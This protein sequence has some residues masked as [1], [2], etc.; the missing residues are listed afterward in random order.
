[1]CCIFEISW[2]LLRSLGYHF[3]YFEG[4]NWEPKSYI[5]DPWGGPGTLKKPSLKKTQKEGTSSQNY[6]HFDALGFHFGSFGDPF[7][8]QNRE[9]WLPGGPLAPRKKQSRKRVQKGA[10]LPIGT[11]S[12]WSQCWLHFSM[13]CWLIFLYVFWITFGI[14]LE[15]FGEPKWSQDH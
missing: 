3:G 14:I 10:D 9:F 7:W 15:P 8:N 4:F 2:G 11:R 5:L 13:I 1:M 12:F 6:L